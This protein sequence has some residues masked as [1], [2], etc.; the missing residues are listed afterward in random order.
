M[1]DPVHHGSPTG[2]RPP[3]N[4]V[5]PRRSLRLREAAKSRFAE[6]TAVALATLECPSSPSSVSTRSSC[7]SR[8][9]SPTPSCHSYNLRSRPSTPAIVLVAEAEP[10]QVCPSPLIPEPSTPTVD[11][12]AR[13]PAPQGPLSHVACPIPGCAWRLPPTDDA[14]SVVAQHLNEVHAI[15]QSLPKGLSEDSVYW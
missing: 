2:I 11:E 14:R 13:T 7:R 10:A 15:L 1:E 8:P 5:V 12:T 3:Q 9:R 4:P 6:P